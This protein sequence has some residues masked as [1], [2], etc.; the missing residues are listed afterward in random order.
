MDKDAMELYGSIN[1][2]I[3][4]LLGVYRGAGTRSGVSENEF[5][6][7]YTLIIADGERSQQD[8]CDERSMSKQTVNTIIMNL[9]KKGYAVLEAV[10]G[11]RN[12][13]VIRLTYEGR[14]YG[15]SIILPVFEAEK[16]AF[17]RMPKDEIA[18]CIT[19]FEKYTIYLKEEFNE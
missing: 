5:W 10:P 18:V 11:T 19:A 17:R 15:E 14:K 12:R 7:W 16:R 1:Q 9:V 2:K 4:E 13:K 8:I 3:K 6:V